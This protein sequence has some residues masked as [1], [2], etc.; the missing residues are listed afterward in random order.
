[1]NQSF[2]NVACMGENGKNSFIAKLLCLYNSNNLSVKY[3]KECGWD[4]VIENYEY[5]LNSRKEE[6]DNKMPV[7]W[8][9]KLDKKQVNLYSIEGEINDTFNNALV[10]CNVGLFYINYK[11]DSKTSLEAEF[12]NQILLSNILGIKNA[13]VYLDF[14]EEANIENTDGTDR[15]KVINKIR[16]VFTKRN[17]KNNRVFIISSFNKQ[18]I[19][20]TF[21]EYFKLEN[22]K[23]LSPESI[24]EICLPIS[25]VFSLNNKY[26]GINGTLIKGSVSFNDFIVNSRT[27]CMYKIEELQVAHKQV[28]KA[29]TG[30]SIGMKIKN[31]GDIEIG[32]ILVHK[33]SNINYFTLITAQIL[34]IDSEFDLNSALTINTIGHDTSVKVINIQKTINNLNKTLQRRPEKLQKGDTGIVIFQSREKLPLKL[35]SNDYTLGSFLLKDLEKG[36][37]GVGIIKGLK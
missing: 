35:Y 19:T 1:M 29:N 17:Y 21:K 11:T 34:L 10:Q 25:N 7:I 30:S 37:I 24:G 33:S 2:V 36:I 4:K 22:R 3:S 26:F 15:S 8:N 16:S 12:K 9:F 14:E 13:I 20:D 28:E 31:G 18:K 32:D 27:K 23:K 5:N 6:I